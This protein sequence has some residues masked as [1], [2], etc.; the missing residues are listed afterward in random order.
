MRRRARSEPPGPAVKIVLIPITCRIKGSLRGAG[1]G[2]A[3]V[4]D[5]VS[6]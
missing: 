6:F 2:I 5:S 4:R 3:V 1:T